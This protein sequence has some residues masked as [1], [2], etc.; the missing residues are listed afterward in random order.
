MNSTVE[1]VLFAVLL[2]NMIYYQ[3]QQ[4]GARGLLLAVPV[5]SD[6]EL[7]SF[8]ITVNDTA[9]ANKVGFE[10]NHNTQITSWCVL[11]NSECGEYIRSKENVGIVLSN[12]GERR[13]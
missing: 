12:T 9:V 5:T 3:L 11:V 2:V 8:H 10:A 1:S 13:D 6:T 7:Q 4:Y